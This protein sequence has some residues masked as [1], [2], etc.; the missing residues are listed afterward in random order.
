MTPWR[1]S[2]KEAFRGYPALVVSMVASLFCGIALTSA[3]AYGSTV[4]VGPQLPLPNPFETPIGC[5]AACTVANSQMP[6]GASYQ[7]PISGVIVRWRLFGADHLN[8]GYRIRVIKHLS[9][10]NAYLGLRSGPL[11]SPASQFET[12]PANL[13]IQAGQMVALNLESQSSVLGFE[14]NPSAPALLWEPPLEDKKLRSSPEGEGLVF[15]FNADIQPPPAIAY[16]AS[17]KG[18][19]KGDTEVTLTG[20]DFTGATAVSFGAE[21]AASFVVDSDE[22]ITAFSPPSATPGSVAVS[23]TTPAGVATS[24]F[25]Y[26]ACVVPKLKKRSLKAAKALL[27]NARC[28]IGRVTKLADA[29]ARTA[30]V[31]SQKPEPGSVLTPGSRVRVTLRPRS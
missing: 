7:A 18:P 29:K 14:S 16:L 19:I 12:F 22:Q 23:V 15:G 17:V 25:R 24:Q 10:G 5:E 2:F 26:L 3:P 21:P 28:H 11:Q 31:S 20:T 4:T 8:A 9:D 30:E 1:G 13:P 27:R 6:V